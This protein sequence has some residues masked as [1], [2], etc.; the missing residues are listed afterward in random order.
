[1]PL[2]LTRDILNECTTAPR[3]TSCTGFTPS[4]IRADNGTTFVAEIGA[5]GGEPG[6]QSITGTCLCIA[7][8]DRISNSLF[9]AD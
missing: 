1:M 9:Y 6:Y 8:A 7:V 4:S 5:S 2:N 3:C